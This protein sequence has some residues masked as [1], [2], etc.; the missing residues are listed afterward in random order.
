MLQIRHTAPTLVGGTVTC[1][2]ELTEVDKRRLVFHVTVA[3]GEKVIGEG[4][5]ER[6]IVNAEK[7]LAKAAGKEM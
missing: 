3:D 5:H 7:F 1:E 6:F 2:S 4:D